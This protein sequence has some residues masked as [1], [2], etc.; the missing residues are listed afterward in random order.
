[1]DTG[2]NKQQVEAISGDAEREGYS[3][4]FKNTKNPPKRVSKSENSGTQSAFSCMKSLSEI[5]STIDQ[6]S[7][8][9]EYVVNEMRNC[10]KSRVHFQSLWLST[11]MIVCFDYT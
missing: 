7:V 5:V 11:I 9:R 10:N 3:T 4:T 6:H 8:F 2:D 1:M